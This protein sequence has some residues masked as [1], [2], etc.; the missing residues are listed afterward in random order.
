MSLL[1]LDFLS[2]FVKRWRVELLLAFQ[3]SG[4]VQVVIGKEVVDVGKRLFDDGSRLEDEPARVLDEH[5]RVFH[6]D[7]LADRDFKSD[8]SVEV[9]VD[10]ALVGVRVEEVAVLHLLLLLI[11]ML[12]HRCKRILIAKVLQ[13]FALVK[14]EGEVE[15]FGRA[16][17]LVAL[18]ATATVCLPWWMNNHEDNL[19]Q[20]EHDE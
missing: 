9:D 7:D 2:D 3:L 17:C 4:G 5:V 16:T 13:D 18:G 6:P 12:C 10:A 1:D 20:L 15:V 11:R 19:V 14:D 8:H